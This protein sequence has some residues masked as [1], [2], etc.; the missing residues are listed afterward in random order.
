[1]IGVHGRIWNSKVY[2]KTVSI[3][4]ASCAVN[5]SGRTAIGYLAGCCRAGNR[6]FECVMPEGLCLT[7]VV[8]FLCGIL[9]LHEYLVDPLCIHVDDLH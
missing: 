8:I 2:S 7:A 9:Q 3:I 1:M 5:R 4:E 6:A